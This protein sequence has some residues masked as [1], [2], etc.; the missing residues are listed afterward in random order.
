MASHGP[1]MFRYVFAYTYTKKDNRI[2]GLNS[3]YVDGIKRVFQSDLMVE[4]SVTSLR[5]QSIFRVLFDAFCFHVTS[6]R[7]SAG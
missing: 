7:S 1:L 6:T 4:Y 3:I 2:A 5:V